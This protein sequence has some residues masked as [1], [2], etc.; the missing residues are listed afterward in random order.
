MSV[1][2]VVNMQ[3]LVIQAKGE[4]RTVHLCTKDHGRCEYNGIPLRRSFVWMTQAHASQ[5]DL[6]LKDGIT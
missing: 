5:F 4:A 1:V 2:P 6:I 3:E